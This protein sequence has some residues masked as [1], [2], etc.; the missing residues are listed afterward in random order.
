M[1]VYASVLPCNYLVAIVDCAM[2]Q[3]LTKGPRVLITERSSPFFD[4]RLRANFK[5][6]VFGFHASYYNTKVC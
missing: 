5:S 3:Q 4:H 2:G 6:S 1:Y